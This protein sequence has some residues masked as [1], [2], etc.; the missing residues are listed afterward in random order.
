LVAVEGAGER[1]IWY[2]GEPDAPKLTVC[3]AKKMAL[4]ADFL[5]VLRDR[6]SPR[7]G[8]LRRYA[9]AVSHRRLPARPSE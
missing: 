6:G 2:F 9:F 4:V 3:T 1:V 8:A 5:T 7:Y